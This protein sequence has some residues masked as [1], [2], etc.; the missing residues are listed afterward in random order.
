MISSS[1]PRSSGPTQ[2]NS[3]SPLGR[4]LTVGWLVLTTWAIRADQRRCLRAAWV[5]FNRT[6][7]VCNTSLIRS[8]E[9]GS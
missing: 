7:Q 4:L 1:R 3:G 5:S 8:T 2:Q 9:G 6:M